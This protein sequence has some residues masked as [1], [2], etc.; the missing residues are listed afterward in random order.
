MAHKATP[1]ALQQLPRLPE[2]NPQIN[3]TW[4]LGTEWAFLLLVSGLMKMKMKAYQKHEASQV[5]IASTTPEKKALRRVQYSSTSI[6]EKRF[7]LE[8]GKPKTGGGA[9]KD[10]VTKKSSGADKPMKRGFHFHEFRS[11]VVEI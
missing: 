5:E 2:C 6:R 4:K 1:S 8:P 7:Q 11:Q 9:P 3:H 10:S